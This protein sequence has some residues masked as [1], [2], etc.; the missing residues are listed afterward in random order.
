MKMRTLAAS[1]GLSVIILLL[2]TMAVIPAAAGTYKDRDGATHAWFI[3]NAH[4]MMWDGAPYVPFGIVFQPKSFAAGSGYDSDKAVVESL[5]NAGVA[6]VL[7]RPGMSI[8]S[9]PVEAFQR[10][11]DLLESNGI[12]YGI[13]LSDAPYAPL[14]GYVINPAENR[15]DG[16]TY[17]GVYS[18]SYSDASNVM[19][20]LCDAKTHEVERIG[21]AIVADGKASVNITVRPDSEKL[22]LFYPERTISTGSADWGLPDLWTDG[23]RHRD[24]LIVYLSKVKFGRGLRYYI[25]PF[26][27]RFGIRGESDAVFPTSAQFHLEYASW[28]SKKYDNPRDVG[29]A[30][31][32]GTHEMR[33]FE[34]AARLLPLWRAGRGVPYIYNDAKG[35][36]YGV[37]PGSSRIWADMIEFRTKSVQGSMDSLADSLKRTVADVP[38]VFTASEMQSVY[39][40]AN[41]FGFD[42]LVAKPGKGAVDTLDAAGKVFAME[43]VSARPMWSLSW[44]EP[45][46]VGFERKEDV[47][48]PV[49]AAR[50]LGCKG[51]IFDSPAES[52]NQDTLRWLAE[53]ASAYSKDNAFAASRPRAVY[54]PLGAAHTSIKQF[55]SGGW[56]LPMLA[57]VNDIYLG[58]TLAGYAMGDPSSQFQDIYVWSIHGKQNIHLYSSKPIMVVNESGQETLINPKKGQVEFTVGE[59]PLVVK[60]MSTTG[61]VPLEVAVEAMKETEAAIAKAAKK[62][63]DVSIY[64][65]QLDRA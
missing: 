49:N 40:A 64:Q 9:V 61:F 48:S 52:A 25:D 38:L 8:S 6:D 44:I 16:I 47:F 59:E 10:V 55:A 58:S 15:K 51:F 27:A 65:Y 33:S 54:Y 45:I 41:K 63:G 42:G 30:W 43:E 26:S 23:D 17:S 37:D 5:R 34:E 20:V 21:K 57:P 31:C 56:W 62:F 1:L 18:R 35:E 13:E 24:R 11:I 12:A 32:T 60:G 19:W 46:A 3:G 53:C 39:Q 29:S 36:K 7:L 14:K 22:L 4:Q 28:L 50:G 2:L